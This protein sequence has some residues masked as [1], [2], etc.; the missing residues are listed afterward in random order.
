MNTLRVTLLALF[1]MNQAIFMQSCAV[2]SNASKIESEKQS[3][4][5]KSSDLTPPQEPG[6]VFQKILKNSADEPVS[7]YIS[8]SKQRLFLYVG[9]T[10]AIN[11]PISSG[12]KPGMTRVGTFRITQKDKTHRSSVY[13][14][15]VDASGNIIRGGID[16]RRDSAP[17][18][19][20]Y[21]GASM[22]YFMRIT[23]RGVGMHA[24]YLPGYPASHGCIRLPEEMS[25]LIYENVSLGTRVIIKQ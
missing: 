15:F 14:S 17:S 7:I 21:M 18:G 12:R 11:S 23:D 8:L 5:F 20:H 13:G 10:I 1:F 19:T 22:M 4:L 24:G 3:S 9:N 16:R 2:V 6:R 25:K